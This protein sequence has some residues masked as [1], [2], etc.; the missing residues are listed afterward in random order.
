MNKMTD[1]K[2]HT[3]YGASRDVFL[4]SYNRDEIEVS[5]N[6]W[7]CSECGMEAPDWYADLTEL[8]YLDCTEE[9]VRYDTWVRKNGQDLHIVYGYRQGMNE[10]CGP[11]RKMKTT[12]GGNE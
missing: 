8:D 10:L 5:P 2:M 6:W 4:S 3:W 11:I 7:R 12:K 1:R 9:E